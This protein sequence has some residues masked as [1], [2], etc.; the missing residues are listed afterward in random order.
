MPE[1]LSLYEYPS[2]CLRTESPYPGAA[3]PPLDEFTYRLQHGAIGVIT[4]AGELF[5]ALALNEMDAVN[6]N[7]EIGDGCWYAGLLAHILRKD[8]RLM[9]DKARKENDQRL[10]HYSQYAPDI[11]K[12]NLHLATAMWV[13]GAGIILDEC[14]RKVYYR[15]RS[16]KS[17]KDK[18]F[19]TLSVDHQGLVLRGETVKIPYEIDVERCG[20][21]LELVVRG[22]YMA[23]TSGFGEDIETICT[24][25][26]MKL[27]KR[28]GD[29]F[30]EFGAITRNLE[31]ERKL[32]ESQPT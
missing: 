30:N 32:L 5:D 14:K 9:V 6:V 19:T 18:F 25:N 1:L 11:K 23:S 2:A 31:A 28:Y 3:L 13:R 7:E 12:D 15:L 20:K 27:A 4:E 26:I 29:K 16:V 21:A 8:F 24:K 17:T 10:D 22:L